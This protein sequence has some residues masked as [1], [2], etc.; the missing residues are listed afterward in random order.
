MIIF[1]YCFTNGFIPALNA[2]KISSST[3]PS[4]EPSLPSLDRNIIEGKPSQHTKNLQFYWLFL[5][6]KKH[7]DRL[8]H[9]HIIVHHISVIEMGFNPTL[10]EESSKSYVNALNMS[11]Y[12][13]HPSRTPS[14]HSEICLQPKGA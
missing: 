2:L 9:C 8:C 11:H 3:M 5:S 12:L 4:I 7:S 14:T 6:T 13:L 1:T 10:E